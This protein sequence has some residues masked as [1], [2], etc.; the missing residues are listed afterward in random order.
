MSSLQLIGYVNKNEIKDMKKG[1]DLS[2]YLQ[3]YKDT[4]YNL[5]VYTSSQPRDWVGLSDYAI[6][7]LADEY[8]DDL[9]TL[10]YQYELLLKQL[11]TKG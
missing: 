5:P 6:N 8:S 11:N 3:S 10:L 1:L 9:Q 4:K 7:R 2:A